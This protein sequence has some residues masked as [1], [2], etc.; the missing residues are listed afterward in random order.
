[1]TL[2]APLVEWYRADI[3]FKL[4]ATPAVSKTVKLISRVARAEAESY[5]PL[6]MDVSGCGS[7]CGQD[8]VPVASSGSVSID[9]SL[10]TFGRQRRFS[11]LLERYTCIE[12]D[13]EIYVTQTSLGDTA[14]HADF[15]RLWKGK[16]KSVSRS[17]GDSPTLNLSVESISL[18]EKYVTRIITQDMAA[19]GETVPAKSLGKS[20][21]ALLGTGVSTPCYCIGDNNLAARYVY[22]YGLA[23]TFEPGSASAFY[24]K[25]DDGIYQ[26]VSSAADYYIGSDDNS[27]GS[28]YP[29][30]YGR[31]ELIVPVEWQTFSGYGER[32]IVVGLRWWM[33]GQNKA[34]TPAGSLKFGI[35]GPPK[36][37]E[38]RLER[39]VRQAEVQKSDYWTQVSGAS[40]FW[41]YAA[42]EKPLVLSQLEHTP[43]GMWGASSVYAYVSMSLSSYVSATD[44]FTSGGI[45]NSYW[46]GYWTRSS[47]DQ[48]LTEV[49]SSYR[50]YVQLICLKLSDDVTATDSEGYRYHYITARQPDLSVTEPDIT[51]MDLCAYLTY[52]IRDDG[53][54]TITG[55]GSGSITKP[56]HI[57]D[58]LLRE[59][60]GSAWVDS[61]LLDQA[62]FSSLYTIFTTGEYQRLVSGTTE[63]EQTLASVVSEIM[64]SCCCA[65]VPQSDGRLAVWPW[66]TQQN[67]K[68]VITDEDM[69]ITSWTINDA[70]SV[71]ND[72]AV[73]YGSDYIT[74]I[75]DDGVTVSYAN[76]KGSVKFNKATS[77]YYSGLTTD[78]EMLYGKRP[79][80]DQ[81]LRFIGDAVSATTFAKFMLMRS[82]HPH[83]LVQAEAP[84]YK[85]R[86]LSIMDVVELL[87][88]ALPSHLGV[89]PD[90]PK[91][92]S[93]GTEI[94]LW[95]GD[96][97]KRASRYRA[98]LIG[99]NLNAPEGR[100]GTWQFT[101]KLI[102]PPHMNDMT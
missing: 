70:S 73:S 35:Y 68:M 74:P 21:P 82:D 14:P 11:D 4:K 10:G 90:A 101:F 55:S 78:S 80:S 33:K 71:I 94:D 89:S 100:A 2:S 36:D 12:Q 84:A 63:G 29:T 96:Y 62:V 83:V 32:Y 17:G 5:W 48:Q 65:L 72:V 57:V 39:T 26:E 87:T 31:T 52:G 25:D 6:L 53:G 59:W 45:G 49:P 79:L 61:G 1:M 41:V 18:P 28:Y 9:D 37:Q 56:H 91:C 95:D 16:I 8:G 97:I 38:P 23:D 46:L 98:Q 92:E 99:K 3:T 60:N 58:L 67:P 50:P 81:S 86:N 30:S 19:T 15:E 76:S 13:I 51:E 44:D 77:S 42:F 85:Y 69:K 7:T 24:A 88:T 22:G 20:V 93:A 64:R 40:D 75:S 43:G 27:A 66:G 47:S 54:L 34:I 102:K